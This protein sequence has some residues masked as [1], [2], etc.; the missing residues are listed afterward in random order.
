MTEEQAFYD[1]PEV[2]SQYFAH[3]A[4]P[5]NP[6]DALERPIF[7]ELAGDFKNLDIL[8]LGCGDAAFGREALGQGARSY[9]GIEASQAMVELAR[10]T[11]AGTSGRV[12]HE[13]IEEWRWLARAEHVLQRQQVD[14][15]TSR[16][17][18]HYVKDLK[19]VFREI[20]QVLRPNGR[21]ILSVEHPVITSNF[22][23]LA[24][25]S[26]TAWLVDNYFCSGERVHKWLGHDVTKYHHTLEEYFDLVANT[27]F[28][29]ECIRESR[30]Q[31]ENFLDES[32][33]HRRLRIP[34]F[35]FIA[36]SKGRNSKDY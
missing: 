19:P 32:E 25:G 29:L 18:L 5:D 27:G 33:Y 6:N 21:L 3:R 1:N 4:R 36:A 2:R 24:A 28:E 7:L 11:L 23:S 16:L 22:E 8:D 34:M 17:A 9:Q 30:P 14:L 35:L 31:R 26:R 12:H 15:V 13:K 20:Y 10:Q